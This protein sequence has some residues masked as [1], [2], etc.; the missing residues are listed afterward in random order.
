MGFTTTTRGTNRI[1]LSSS[2]GGR[3]SISIIIFP[4]GCCIVFL[5]VPFVIRYQSRHE[6]FSSRLPSCNVPLHFVNSVHKLDNA[7]LPR[8]SFTT[9]GAIDRT[10]DGNSG[11]AFT[12]SMEEKKKKRAKK[13][14]FP[15]SLKPIK[16]HHS[17]FPITFAN[18]KVSIH[19]PGV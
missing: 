12:T 4:I 18:H 6:I 1:L 11:M 17:H 2:G 16:C 9:S 14:K 15:D 7:S 13:R 19:T 8:S 5:P 3:G 10:G